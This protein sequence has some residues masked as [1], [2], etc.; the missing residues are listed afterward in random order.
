MRYPSGTWRCRGAT[1]LL[2]R[3]I[4]V[5]RNMTP[6]QV[7]TR[8]RLLANVADKSA[9]QGM[10]L[11][12]SNEVLRSGVGPAAVTARVQVIPSMV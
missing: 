6:Q 2:G 5:V 10:R 9:T 1:A 3:V 4:V 11:H 7:F 12:V 8:E